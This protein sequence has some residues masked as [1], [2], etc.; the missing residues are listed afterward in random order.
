MPTLQAKKWKFIKRLSKR[1][2]RWLTAG[3]LLFVGF[4]LLPSSFDKEPM[5]TVIESVDGYLLGAKIAADGQWRFPAEGRLPDKYAKA[6]VAFEDRRFF[7]HPGIDPISVGRALWTNIRKGKVVEGGSTISMQTVRLMRKG[8][9]RTIFEKMIEATLALRLE[10]RYSK[11]EI[12]SLYARHAPFG[13]N[14]VGIDAAAWRYFGRPAADLSWAEAAMLAV[15]PNTPS[16]IHP[17]RNREALLNKRNALLHQLCA[18]GCFS[19]DDLP[20]YCAEAL[21]DK[22]LPLPTDAPH[23]LERLAQT[24]SGEN[25]STTIR[26]HLQQRAVEVVNRHAMHQSGNNVSNVAAIII[27][28][29]TGR[30][31]AYVGNVTGRANNEQGEKVDI[32]TAPRST[33]SI[34]KPFLYAAMLDEGT[35]LP[36]MLLPDIPTYIN[37]FIPQNYSKTYDG[38]VPAH[39]ALERSL[40]IPAVLLL[41]EYG[42]ERFHLLLRKMG[43]STVVYEPSH[44]GLSLVLGGAEAKLWDVSNAYAAMARTMNRFA[45]RSGQYSSADWQMPFFNL[46][47]SSLQQPRDYKLTPDAII[48]AAACW[49]VLNSLAE[50]NRPEGEGEWRRFPSSR[51][52]AWKTGTSYGNR[53]A[54]AVGT[55]PLYT[56]GVWVGNASGEGR[57]MLTGVTAAAPVLFDLFNILPPTGWFRQPYDEMT[58]VLLCRQSGHRATPLCADADTAWILNAALESRPCPY[59]I[60]VH[61]DRTGKYRVTSECEDPHRMISRSWFVLP[62]AQ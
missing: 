47:D 7:W 18:K 39:A 6:L 5:S 52:V 27:E 28:N 14:V 12:L 54:W 43:F 13:G 10:F 57:P 4:L 36:A 33:G 25:I 44:Y 23:L 37:G 40:N 11:Q 3:I 61:L 2:K 59:H 51:K 22:P 32:I 45:S 26:Y 15:L 41:Q 16:L 17:G 60:Q 20:L 62:P 1:K 29:E 9:S 58:Q 34:I 8:K 56:V 31:L 38:A 21:P 30:V 24:N 49:Q 53:D 19:A 35:L 50:V 55:T 42:V 46:K 48:S